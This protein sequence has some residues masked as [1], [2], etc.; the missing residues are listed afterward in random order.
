LLVVAFFGFGVLISVLMLVPGGADLTLGA[1]AFVV[2]NFFRARAVRWT[3]IGEFDVRQVYYPHGSKKF[4]VYNDH[5]TT[6]A[7]A[8]INVRLTGYTGALTDGFGLSVE[9]L[10]RLLTLWRERALRQSK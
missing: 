2:R 3:D 6:G 9:E 8:A 1:D 5:S 7:L 4:V 10:L